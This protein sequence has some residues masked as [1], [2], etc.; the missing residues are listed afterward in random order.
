M[1]VIKGTV[2]R[3]AKDKRFRQVKANKTRAVDQYFEDE[4]L[5][6]ARKDNGMSRERLVYMDPDDFL[7]LAKHG[8]DPAKE[9]TV[10]LCLRDKIPLSS[11][12]YLMVDNQPEDDEEVG[13]SQSAKNWLVT[14]HEGRHRARALRAIGMKEIPVIIK[15]ST[16]RWAQSKNRPKYV[17]AQ[18]PKNDALLFSDVIKED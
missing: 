15:H 13:M 3:L 5:V 12:P 8:H 7:A 9:R 18:K 1:I 16:M 14:G 11:I 10:A 2:K 17:W 6:W 4:A